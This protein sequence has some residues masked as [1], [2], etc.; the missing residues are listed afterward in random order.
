[1]TPLCIY[2][3]V[4]LFLCCLSTFVYL[5]R[6]ESAMTELTQKFRQAKMRT[7]FSLIRGILLGTIITIPALVYFMVKDDEEP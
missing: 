1:M 3:S 2:I 6:D 7:I 5:K 4:S